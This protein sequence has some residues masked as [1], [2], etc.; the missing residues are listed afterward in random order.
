MNNLWSQFVQ[1]TEELYQ[2][3]SLR[4]RDDNKGIWLNALQAQNGAN[5]LEVG[6]AGGI[7]CHKIKTWLPGVTVTGLDRDNAHIDYARKK[8]E[9]LGLDCAFINGDATALPFPD[10]SFDLCFSYTVIEHVPTEPF[11]S[12]Q[13]RVLRR[14][15]RIVVFSVRTKMGL[16]ADN[17]FLTVPEEQELFDK[18]WRGSEAFGRQNHIGGYELKERDFPRVLEQAG[19]TDIN[20]DFLTVTDYCPDNACVSDEVAVEQINTRRLHATASV[21]KALRQNPGGL[22]PDEKKRLLGMI[23]ARFDH[24]LAQYRSGDKQWDMSVSVC[25]AAGGRK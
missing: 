18:A 3:R 19:F 7:F 12:E 10:G 25:L 6:C 9:E 5:I 4:F 21:E 23:N 17:V 13:Y 2:S 8:S 24:R 14:G 16:A 11:L 1:T 22:S 15:G 20:I